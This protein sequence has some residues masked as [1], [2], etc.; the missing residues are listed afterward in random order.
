MAL[1]QFQYEAKNR[2]EEIVSGSVEAISEESA[3][4][5][6]QERGL[7]VLSLVGEE[8]GLLKMDVGGWFNRPNNKDVVVFT[9]Q[10]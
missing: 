1:L 4:E 2:R 8:R 7:T 10:L 5:T 6:L 9:R 3:L